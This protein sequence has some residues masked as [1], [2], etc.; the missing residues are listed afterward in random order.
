MEYTNLLQQALSIIEMRYNEKLNEMYIANGYG[1]KP[2]FANKYS[3]AYTSC[4]DDID[5]GIDNPIVNASVYQD[6]KLVNIDFTFDEFKKLYR[7]VK[8]IYKVI[9]KKYQQYLAELSNIP[10]VERLNEIIESGQF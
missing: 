10:T 4:L 2:M 5:E 3:I 6:D 7:E 8:Q 1:I 9:E